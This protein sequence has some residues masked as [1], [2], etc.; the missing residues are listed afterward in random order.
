[1]GTL[2]WGRFTTAESCEEP[3]A[4]G[5]LDS[6][7][8]LGRQDSLLPKPGL[9]GPLAVLAILLEAWQLLTF[10][11]APECGQN[12]LSASGSLVATC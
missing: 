11:G 5:T 8:H 3:S 9:K 10:G 7:T 4:E 6:K 2:D 1:M 12:V